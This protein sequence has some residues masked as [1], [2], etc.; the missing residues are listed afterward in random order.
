M[1]RLEYWRGRYADL[2][3]EWIPTTEISARLVDDLEPLFRIATLLERLYDLSPLR[4]ARV[5]IIGV[6]R[7][8]TTGPR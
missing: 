2:R 3:R 8:V 6:Y 7:T 4:R 1:R 5:H